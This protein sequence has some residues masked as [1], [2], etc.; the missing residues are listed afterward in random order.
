[1]ALALIRKLPSPASALGGGGGGGSAYAE[2]HAFCVDRFETH[3]L[4]K[5]RLATSR[6]AGSNEDEHGKAEQA[7]ARG[8]G[9]GGVCGGAPEEHILF[10]MMQSGLEERALGADVCARNSRAARL[11]WVG[12]CRT[13]TWA[14]EKRGSPASRTR[15]LVRL[16]GGTVQLAMPGLPP[17]CYLKDPR[18]ATWSYPRS[19]MTRRSHAATSAK[20]NRLG[21]AASCRQGWELLVRRLSRCAEPPGD[22]RLLLS[23][24]GSGAQA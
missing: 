23:D 7:V 1:M 15:V 20:E 12:T 2:W 3:G 10:S 6:L 9:G 19:A 11:P 17:N 18:S 8:G 24:G 4:W 22:F 16:L 14:A 13:T 21:T 5:L